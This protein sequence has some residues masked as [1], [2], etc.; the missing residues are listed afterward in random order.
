MKKLLF[1]LIAM[2]SIAVQANAMSYEQARNEALFLTDKMAYELNLN[3][4]QYE[5]A[6]EINLDYL[7]S[8]TNRYNVFSVSW[9]HRNCDL[10]FILYP[11]QW[12]AFIAASYFYRPLVWEAGYW[13][14]SVYARYPHRTYFYFGRPH[15]YATYRGGHSWHHNGGHSYYEHH[16]HAYHAV[17]DRRDHH[18]MRDRWARGDYNGSNRNTYSSTHVT[19]N[20]RNR[21]YNNAGGSGGNDRNRSGNADTGNGRN[22][23]DNNA[24]GSGNNDRNRGGITTGYPRTS[25]TASGSSR[26]HNIQSMG[27]RQT[28]VRQSGSRPNSTYSAPSRQSSVS[29]MPTR[30]SSVGNASARNSS[31]S[32]SAR[33]DIGNRMNQANSRVREM[34]SNRRR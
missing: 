12:E 11:W 5:A 34:N 6:Y 19:G 1:T 16:H 13:H 17:A 28:T 32:S 10:Q 9:E 23:S 26:Q 29:N 22:R 14:F 21:T 20:N 15:F 25:G 18:G 3:D 4:A 33:Q 27:S 30:S 24:G 8:V 2:L 31:I 7:M